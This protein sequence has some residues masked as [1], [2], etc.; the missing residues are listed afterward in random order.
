MT[1]DAKFLGVGKWSEDYNTIEVERLENKTP[2]PEH[3]K[4]FLEEKYPPGL[5]AR[6]YVHIVKK[7]SNNSKRDFPVMLAVEYMRETEVAPFQISG[8]WLID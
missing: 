7:S 2:D 5:Y 8:E 1:D 3:L 4:G 6:Y